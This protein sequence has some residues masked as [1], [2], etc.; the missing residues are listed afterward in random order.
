MS[1]TLNSPALQT[2]DAPTNVARLG[3]FFALEKE[4]MRVQAARMPAL[5]GWGLKQQIGHFLYEDAGHASALLARRAELPGGRREVAPLDDAMCVA[6]EDALFAPDDYGFCAA[7]YLG[8]KPLLVQAYREHLARTTTASDLPGRQILEQIIAEEERQIAWM[9]G[10]LSVMEASA[11]EKKVARKTIESIG[12]AVVRGGGI[13]GTE[14]PHGNVA[15]PRLYHA[16]TD[17]R[18]EPRQKVTLDFEA[19][20]AFDDEVK[21]TVVAHFT[22]Y[23]REMAAAETVAVL[24]WEAPETMPWE[25]F[26]AAA[27]H[28]WDE[29]RHCQAGQ[30]RLEE[31]GL[32]IWSVPVQTG[33]YNIRARMPLL[34]RYAF[35]TQVEE[36]GSFA[37]K[38]EKEALYRAAGDT[39]SADMT[40]YDMADERMHVRYGT[41]WIPELQRALGDERTLDELVSDARALHTRVMEELRASQ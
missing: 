3:R 1:T 15:M 32:D 33:N 41:K 14:E 35:I 16:V 39:V 22:M 18:R 4:L 20:D 5:Q 31:L 29:V 21:Q 38:A 24:L 27:R 11:D 9:E 8:F 37:Y 30:Q 17:A 2:L 6:I 23:F 28:F 13:L 10:A 25:F 26:A 19:P 40:A 7:L 36:A 12:E 34:E